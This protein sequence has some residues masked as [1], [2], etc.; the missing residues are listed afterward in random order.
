MI[1]RR[2]L[3]WFSTTSCAV[4]VCPA[5]FSLNFSKAPMYLMSPCTR[6]GQ[7]PKISS[8]QER[9]P[10]HNLWG[11][12]VTLWSLMHPPPM[13]INMWP[14]TDRNGRLLDMLLANLVYLDYS[15]ICYSLVERKPP[16][17]PT[18]TSSEKPRV[19]LRFSQ[20]KRQNHCQ[21]VRHGGKQSKD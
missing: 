21:L 20:R 15:S 8:S 11:E 2:S 17:P 10:P 16:P 6:W 9:A 18:S 4:S 14:W 19:F 1:I 5:S 7:K 3:L 12:R 13:R